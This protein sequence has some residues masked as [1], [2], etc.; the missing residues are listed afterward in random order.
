MECE[1]IITKSKKIKIYP[2]KDQKL[3]LNNW[4]AASR[5]SYNETIAYLKQENTI[6]NW[7]TIKLWLLK[8]LP[9]WCREIPFQIKA[10]AIKDA[11]GAVK[12]AK[13]KFKKT[14]KFNEVKFR[15]IKNPTQNIYIPKSAIKESGIYHTILGKLNY[16]E[17]LPKNLLDSR[18]VFENGNYYLAIS[19]NSTAINGDNQARVVSLDPG[20]RTFQTFFSEE[21]CGKIG[22]GSIGKIQRLC[23]YLDNLMG[24][25]SK[26]KSKKKHR[27]RIA[28][29]RMRIKIRNLISELHWKTAKFFCENFDIILLP[30]FDTSEMVQRGKRKLNS[31][32]TR[33]MLT[34]SHYLFK[35]RIMQKAKELKKLVIIV[36]EAYTSK[37]A[38]WTGEIKHKLGSSKT[39]TSQGITLD[40]DYNGA[41]GIM[42]RALVDTPTKEILLQNVCFS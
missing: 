2:N 12:N 17:Q 19:Y 3:L 23:Y 41:R 37:T 21:Y 1:N 4:F 31:K 36:N 14:K 33:Q 16:S 11:C 27:M 22:N 39:I 9:E 34:F 42:L 30:S 24:R 40:R 6:A 5:K 10:I 32:S 38:S 7:M 25:I 29:N 13:I 18:L 28:A 8:S 35:E 26:T 20:V 15:S